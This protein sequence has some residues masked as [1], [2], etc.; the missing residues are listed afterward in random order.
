MVILIK[1]EWYESLL[2]AV[3]SFFGLWLFISLIGLIFFGVFSHILKKHN[4]A[5]TVV[6]KTKYDNI[7]KLFLVLKD[8]DIEVDDSY[9]TRLYSI[10]VSD[11]EKQDS[12]TCAKARETLSMLRD[13]AMFLSE[14]KENVSKNEIVKLAKKNILDIDI[15]YRNHIAMYNADVLG[16]NYWIK[17]LPN[18]LLFKVFRVKEKNLIS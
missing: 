10:Q 13:E 5:L 12:V 11:F 7:E 17:F 1:L 3:G 14:R 2:I 6:L 16:Y 8:S 9:L 18:R 4:R 15:I